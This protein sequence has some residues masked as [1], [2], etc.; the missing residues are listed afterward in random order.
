M[1]KVPCEQKPDKL[2]NFLLLIVDTVEHCEQQCRA[3]VDSKT[4][5]LMILD[6]EKIQRNNSK[7]KNRLNNLYNDFA[8][9]GLLPTV[10][11]NMTIQTIITLEGVEL[12]CKSA[13]ERL[14]KEAE[15]RE[16]F[17]SISK[18]MFYQN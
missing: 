1:K 18:N 9:D 5:K 13:I 12:Y 8:Q 10:D 16:I 15:R 17:E 6:I 4:I 3:G 11:K 14:K 7:S 2:K